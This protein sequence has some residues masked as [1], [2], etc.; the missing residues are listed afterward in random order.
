MNSYSM[1]MYLHNPQVAPYPIPGSPVSN[2]QAKFLCTFS[3]ILSRRQDATSKHISLSLSLE[4]S[5]IANA[6]PIR[7][8][9]RP[10]SEV[11]QVLSIR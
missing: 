9:K 1:G 4:Y 10:I 2:E 6:I 5:D 7:P 11:K 8:W 3:M